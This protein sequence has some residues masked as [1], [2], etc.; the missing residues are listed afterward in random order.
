[1]RTATL[2]FAW[3]SPEVAQLAVFIYQS[4]PSPVC[5]CSFPEVFDISRSTISHHLTKLVNAGVLRREK[6]GKWAYYSLADEFDARILE[7]VSEQLAEKSHARK[8]AVKENQLSKREEQKMTT[9]LFA[10]QQNAGR[11]QIAAA[12][13]ENLAVSNITVLSA[14]S[15]PAAQVHSQ[16]REV[17]AEIG[18]APLTQPTKLDPAKVKTSD[19][20]IT[21]GCGESCPIFPGT[22]YED[23]DVTDPAGKSLAEVRRIRDEIATRV[24]D[25]LQ[26]I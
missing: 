24:K 7:I 19:W 15:N 11:S 21:M 9:I 10:C 22:H 26:R 5:A 8:A 18:L 20:V 13:A 25:L 6:S 17:L 1:M 23:W 2:T 16:V 3:Q 14:G 4:D 12:I